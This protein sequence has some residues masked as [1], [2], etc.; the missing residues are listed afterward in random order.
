MCLLIKHLGQLLFL[1]IIV[2]LSHTLVGDLRPTPSCSGLRSFGYLAQTNTLHSDIAQP[3]R[4]LATG[5]GSLENKQL[6][7]EEES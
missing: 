3:H 1:F 4:M 7:I 2:G 6:G 5:R